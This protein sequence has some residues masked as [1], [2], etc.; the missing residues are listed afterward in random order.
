MQIE[1]TFRDVKNHRWGLSLRYARSRDGKRLEVL[2]LIAA[3]TTFLHWLFG[4]IARQQGLARHFQAN[5]VRN[6]PVLSVV[7]VGQQLLQRTLGFLPKE[8]WDDAVRTLRAVIAESRQS[9]GFVGIP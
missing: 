5:T 1:E 6:R 9:L 2:L 7:F 3:L 4:L 8:A